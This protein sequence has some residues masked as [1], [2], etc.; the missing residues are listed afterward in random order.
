MQPQRRR[1]RRGRGGNSIHKSFLYSS[2]PSPLRGSSC[3]S[4]SE[5]S[6]TYRYFTHPYA[7]MHGYNKLPMRRLFLIISALF[8]AASIMLAVMWVQSYSHTD[9]WLLGGPGHDR[10]GPLQWTMYVTST[11]GE[12]EIEVERTLHPSNVPAIWQSYH[13]RG[14]IAIPL[15]FWGNFRFFADTSSATINNMLSSLARPPTLLMDFPYWSA[16]T[17]LALPSVI[18]LLIWKRREKPGHCLMCG[19]DLR[20]SPDRCPECG[21]PTPPRSNTGSGTRAPGAL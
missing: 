13:S 3:F 12:V 19:Y 10:R 8:L 2:R 17:L 4:I 14:R 1:E 15:M 16:V 18:Y 6:R 20:A 9:V 21:T 11:R 7:S 5:G